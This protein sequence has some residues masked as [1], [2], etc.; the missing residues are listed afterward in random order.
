MVGNDKQDYN[1]HFLFPDA[2]VPKGMSGR[3]LA[4][5]QQSRGR[6][7]FY[8]PQLRLIVVLTVPVERWGYFT[9]KGKKLEET[10]PDS[11]APKSTCRKPRFGVRRTG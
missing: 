4:D 5:E 10:V 2:K 9:L 3:A 11:P 8:S 6:A 1:L 7:V